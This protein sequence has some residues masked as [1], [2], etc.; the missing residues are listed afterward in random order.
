M[1]GI[2]EE[3]RIEGNRKPGQVVL[4]ESGLFYEAPGYFDIR[5]CVI[6]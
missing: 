4:F 1:S 5:C 2:I 3:L 6:T